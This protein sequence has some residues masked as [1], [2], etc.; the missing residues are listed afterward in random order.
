MNIFK[1]ITAGIVA[2]AMNVG[3]AIVQLSVQ[4]VRI[5]SEEILTVMVR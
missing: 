2:G 3:M 4:T 5:I 1:K